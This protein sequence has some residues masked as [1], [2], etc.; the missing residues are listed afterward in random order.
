MAESKITEK[1]YKKV[2]RQFIDGKSIKSLEESLSDLELTATEKN[3]LLTQVIS[4]YRKDRIRRA[5]KDLI[6]GL[7][8][9]SVNLIPMIL[10][11][12][13]EGF[14]FK[15]GLINIAA[16]FACRPFLASYISV[17]RDKKKLPTKPDA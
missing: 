5:K 14:T 13:I 16:L 17:Q 3:N 10:L 4:D 7:V 1:Q 9:I 6:I 8:F 12:T 15:F 11:L 2:I